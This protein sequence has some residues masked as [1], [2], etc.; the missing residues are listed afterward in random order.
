MLAMP[1]AGA[2]QANV[3]PQNVNAVEEKSGKF[4]VSSSKK[5]LTLKDDSEYVLLVAKGTYKQGQNSVDVTIDADTLTYIDQQTAKNGEVSFD[6]IPKTKTNS[7]IL[8]GGDFNG[9]TSPVVIGYIDAK[10]VTVDISITVNGSGQSGNVTNINVFLVIDGQE[11]PMDGNDGSFL[12]TETN[13]GTYTVRVKK[14]GYLSALTT[15]TIANQAATVAPVEMFG[16]DVD[17]SNDIN[18]Q[19][20][21]SLIQLWGSPDTPPEDQH[22]DIDESGDITVQD[23]VV[24]VQNFNKR[25]Q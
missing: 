21:V 10:G 25:G 7:V 3:A 24:L 9:T 8:L 17:G 2:V 14:P 15:V 6:F 19:D 22:P 4:T 1:C 12:L 23:L 20:L 18:V 5:G 13:N 16:G 11:T